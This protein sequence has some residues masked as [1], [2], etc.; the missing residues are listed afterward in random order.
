LIR[1]FLLWVTAALLSGL[2]VF[3]DSS[4]E[5]RGNWSATLDRPVERYGH[6]IMGDISEWER[7]CLSNLVERACVILS[8]DSVFEDMGARLFD[9]DKDGEPEAI[10]VESKLGL[11]AALVVYDLENAALHRTANPN[12]GTQNRWLAPIGVADFNGDGDMDVAYV[13]RP[14]LAK[15]LRVWTYRDGILTEIASVNGVTN[16]SIGEPFIT[17]SIRTCN[18]RPEMILNDAGRKNVVS[19]FFVGDKLTTKT[20]G[21]YKTPQSVLKPPKC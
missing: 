21:A 11:G 19:V 10:V 6:G 16:H 12:I 1:R 2:P 3:G 20:L 18:G 9:I 13:D 17:S 5:T 14:H 4:I 8:E 15:T 7:L